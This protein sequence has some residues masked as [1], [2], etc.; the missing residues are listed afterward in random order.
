M[1]KTTK[2]NTNFKA[3]LTI[4]FSYKEKNEYKGESEGQ[5]GLIIWEYHTTEGT[6]FPQVCKRL[7]LRRCI[8]NPKSHIKNRVKAGVESWKGN[9]GQRRALLSWLPSQRYRPHNK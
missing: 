3:Q 4:K 2:R 8:C 9:P 7:F 1:H 5:G 6:A